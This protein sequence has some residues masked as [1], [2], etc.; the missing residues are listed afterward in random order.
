M[1]TPGGFERIAVVNRGEP[2]MRLINAVEE[3][4]HA[5]HTAMKTI[6]LYTEPDRRA[7]FVRR[8]DEA[9]SLGPATFVDSRGNRQVSYL[10]YQRLQTALLDTNADAAWVGWGFV[11]EHAAF[12]AL[13]DRLGVTFIGPS[14]DVMSRLGDKIASKQM[15]ESS[16]VPV[17]QWSGGA[18]ATI[19]EA[20][21]QAARIG[22]P[23]LIKATAGGGGRGMRRVE[24]LADLEAA[25]TSARAEALNAF[26]DD[27]VFL[28]ALVPE[29]KH[30]EVQ[31]VGD[32]AGTVWAVGV[33]DCSV[34]RNHQKLLE[35]AP[36]PV[37]TAEQDREIR[38]AAARLGT[39]AGYQN[40]GTVEF[41]FDPDTGKF[42]FMEVNARLQVE[43][44]V[45]ELTTGLDLVKLQLHVASGG[46]LT[47]EAPPTA[48]HAIEARINAEDPDAG[49]RPAPGKIELLRLPT[50]PGLRIDTGVEE[51]DEIPAEFDSMIAK[52]I[53][54]GGTREE[55]LARLRRG[56]ADSAIVVRDGSTN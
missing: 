10:D 15:A 56:L 2:A 8:A 22:Y 17:A 49:F 39:A 33:R 40:A 48:G 47:G 4:N 11:A 35:E 52:V 50:G 44:P 37:L 31:I 34:Q 30:I 25:F 21:A 13:C 42:W 38:E 24:S 27:T 32:A 36:S 16:G 1:P 55:A 51:G 12:A 9:Y 28:E 46:L 54:V 5:H 6:A 45:T 18:V 43:H 23:L 14:A 53:A 41:L 19:E 7:M 20:R 3:Y 26:G 29:A